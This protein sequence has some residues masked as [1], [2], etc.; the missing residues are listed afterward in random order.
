[1]ALT[2]AHAEKQLLMVVPS[3]SSHDGR[4]LNSVLLG[5][6]GGGMGLLYERGNVA[7]HYHNITFALLAT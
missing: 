5:L 6:R 1:M 3:T 7:D 2:P 4:G